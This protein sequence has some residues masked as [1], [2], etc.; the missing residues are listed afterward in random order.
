MSDYRTVFPMSGFADVPTPF[1]FYDMDLLHRTLESIRHEV[2]VDDQAYRVH[3]AIK[4]N[5]N[6]VLLQTISHYGFGA[7]CVSGGEIRAAIES[8]FPATGIVYAGVGKTDAEIALGLDAGI[9]CFNVESLPELE[10]IDMIS[11][12]KNTVANVALRVNPNIDAHTHHY[13]T[14]GLEENKFGINLDSLPELVRRC[15][16]LKH[17]ELTGLH[18]HIG[19]Q[20]LTMEPYRLLCERINDL[21][22]ELDAYGVNLR[23][24]NVGGGLGIDYSDP[25]THPI[26]D[27]KSYFAV[28]RRHLKLRQGQ[29]LHFELGRSIVAQ[30]GSLI[31]RVLYVKH[32]TSRQFAIVDAG[33][34]E[35]IR[36]A[37][38]G[39]HHQIQNISTPD[40]PVETYD[41]VGP[42]CESS[43]YFGRDEQL[44]QLRRGDFIA[45]RSA[46][47]YGRSH[48]IALQLPH[49]QQIH[50]FRNT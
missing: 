45:L 25:D 36:P 10:I 9:S 22:S 47:A 37:L 39:A 32:G 6:P 43:D 30:C 24:I 35:L 11:A 13:I 31:S 2:P 8:G 18:F 19:S 20:I 16:E 38:Y 4:A 48:G 1:Y 23:T 14:T 15:S 7:D 50:I 49:A 29:Q 5:A 42:V 21:Q 46:G 28:F 17:V 44:P 12:G 41:V 3:Y 33:M 34:T 26:P 27:F 40:A